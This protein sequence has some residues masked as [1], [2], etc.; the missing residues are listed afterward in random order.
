MAEELGFRLKLGQS[1]N[2]HSKDGI[3][4][5]THSVAYSE[6]VHLLQNYLQQ[7]YS[8]ELRLINFNLIFMIL[9]WL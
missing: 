4:V 3:L 7:T 6:V 8:Q 2:A 1:G 9:F 5:R